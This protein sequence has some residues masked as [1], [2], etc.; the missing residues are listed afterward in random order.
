MLKSPLDDNILR[1]IIF[2]C[3]FGSQF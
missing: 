2:V 1:T 3:L